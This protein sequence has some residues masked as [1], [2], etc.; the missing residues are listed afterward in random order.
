MPSVDARAARLPWL[1]NE[2]DDCE[3]TIVFTDNGVA[4]SNGGTLYDV[5]SAG[6]WFAGVWSDVEAA[7]AGD[8]PLLE[9]TVTIPATGTV[10]LAIATG[11]LAGLG[12]G[13]YWWAFVRLTP[14]RKTFYV[15]QF[16]VSAGWQGEGS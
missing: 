6:D 9:A 8:D 4:A 14:S 7:S 3:M 13:T 11:D 15:G 10:Q 1:V 2:A 12:D 5:G 16:S